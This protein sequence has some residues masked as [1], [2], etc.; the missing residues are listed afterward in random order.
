MPAEGSDFSGVDDLDPAMREVSGRLALAQA[1]ARRLNTPRGALPDW[2]EYGF[3]LVGAIGTAMTDDQ[4]KQ[5]LQEQ[6]MLEEEVEDISTSIERTPEGGAI[7]S[8]RLFDGDGP[9][10][11]TVN[12]S[13]L[14]IKAIIPGDL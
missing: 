2:P 10:E 12:I 9:F 4:I 5:K 6:A 13:D 1:Y 8:V 11:F 3:D 14:D 7:V